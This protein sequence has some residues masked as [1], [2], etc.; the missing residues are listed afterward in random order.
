[1]S[2]LTLTID[3]TPESATLAQVTQGAGTSTVSTAPSPLPLEDLGSM[4][5]ARHGDDSSD[6]VFEP[7][8][9]EDL[10]A[11]TGAAHLP[12][13]AP[14]EALETLTEAPRPKDDF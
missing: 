8:P 10:E 9:L 3:I 14:P 13:P 7:L 1:M 2:T 11:L 12:E 6:M 5:E 4:T